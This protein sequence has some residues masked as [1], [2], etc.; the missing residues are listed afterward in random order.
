M[1]I[2]GSLYII[3]SDFLSS[4]FSNFKMISFMAFI[5]KVSILFKS[6]SFSSTDLICS[7]KLLSFGFE[8]ELPRCYYYRFL[9]FTFAFAFGFWLF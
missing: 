1:L 8:L 7:I 4:T 2:D 6:N 5:C 9:L 3:L